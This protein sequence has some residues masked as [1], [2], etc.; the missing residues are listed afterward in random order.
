[1]TPNMSA[2]KL[3]EVWH[4][5]NEDEAAADL[6]A[7]PCIDAI[8]NNN[9]ETQAKS[10]NKNILSQFKICIDRTLQGAID[11]NGL[12]IDDTAESVQAF[13]SALVKCIRR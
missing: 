1:M 2:T 8:Q 3:G 10:Q 11:D 6:D 7:N 4:Q 9:D 12:P 5:I 13:F